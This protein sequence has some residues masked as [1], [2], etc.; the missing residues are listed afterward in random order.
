M[1]L[2]R[3]PLSSRSWLILP[4]PVPVRMSVMV[5]LRGRRTTYLTLEARP[6]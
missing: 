5:G 3:S 4:E 1:S 6:T 2:R